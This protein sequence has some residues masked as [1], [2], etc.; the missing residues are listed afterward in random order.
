MGGGNG[1]PL[2]ARGQWNV[3]VGVL[4]GPGVGKSHYAQARARQLAA[5]ARGGCYVLAHDPTLSVR[6]RDVQRHDT[7]AHLYAAL[8]KTPGGIHCLDVADGRRVVA[9]ALVVAAA[10]VKAGRRGRAVPTLVLLDEVCAVGNMSPSYLDPVLAEAYALRR[11]R[12]IGWV[13]C[14]QRP[15]QAHPQIWELATEVVMFRVPSRK[16]LDRLEDMGIPAATLARVPAL[17]RYEYVA[18][19][20]A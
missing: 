8:A 4:G 14:S 10:A 6:G 5:A 17:R 3:A 7:E 19:R 15:Q 12:H 11:H 1:A 13:F 20:L 18:H 9:A 16:Q 2:I